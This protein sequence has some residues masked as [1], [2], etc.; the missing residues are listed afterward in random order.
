M[1]FVERIRGLPFV[2]RS[3]NVNPEIETYS[4]YILKQIG[5]IYAALSGMTDEQLN[6]RPSVQGANSAYVI[7]THVFGNARAWVLGIACGKP[8]RRDRPAEFV[9]SGT[10]E[11]LGRATHALSGEIEAALAELGPARLDSRLVPP[12]ELWGEGDPEEISVREALAHVLEHASMHLGQ[13]QVTRDVVLAEAS[14]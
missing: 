6:Q 8:I 14:P 11:A 4:N 12:Q 13:R 2:H 1:E 3:T 5:D 10:Y 9:S 7:A